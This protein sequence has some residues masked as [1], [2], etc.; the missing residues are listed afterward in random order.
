[1]FAP[2]KRTSLPQERLE[3]LTPTPQVGC[4]VDGGTLRLL[5][6]DELVG[7][8]L[9]LGGAEALVPV[10]VLQSRRSGGTTGRLDTLRLGRRTEN[11]AQNGLQEG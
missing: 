5:C 8:A 1:M 3:A 9:D 2:C 6:N 4:L 11:I 10:V 7:E